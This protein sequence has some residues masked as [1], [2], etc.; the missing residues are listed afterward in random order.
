MHDGIHDMVVPAS[1]RASAGS[2]ADR[3]GLQAHTAAWQGAHAAL[4]QS[5]AAK[6]FFRL[7]TGHV[8]RWYVYMHLGCVPRQ[9]SFTPLCPMATTMKLIT[10]WAVAGM[11]PCSA[12]LL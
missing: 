1:C 3:L 7:A 2:A 10:P 8:S 11:L 9:C 6:R 4:T 5:L 12:L